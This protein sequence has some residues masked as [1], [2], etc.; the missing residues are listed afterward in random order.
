MRLVGPLKGCCLGAVLGRIERWWMV[1]LVVRSNKSLQSRGVPDMMFTNHFNGS[2]KYKQRTTKGR[3][4][5]IFTK[6]MTTLASARP[7]WALNSFLV[8]GG[9]LG[10]SLG[11]PSG[12]FF[13]QL[14]ISKGILLVTQS[15]KL[16]QGGPDPRAGTASVDYVGVY[17]IMHPPP[18]ETSTRCCSLPLPKKIVAYFARG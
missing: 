8:T 11:R 14:C 7:W 10:G 15:A 1:M 2:S 16:K 12:T 4:V 9:C 6:T 3:S 18:F 17:C 13:I 5:H